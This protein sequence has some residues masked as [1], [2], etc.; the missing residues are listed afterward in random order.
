M[1][2]I[3]TKLIAAAAVCILAAVPAVNA[4]LSVTAS[5][6][7]GVAVSGASQFN[8]D[9]L[10]LS[11]AG[12]TVNSL[13]VIGSTVVVSF[14]SDGQ[15]VNLPNQS[16]YAAP[17]LSVNNGIGFGSHTPDLDQAN[18]QDSTH[19]LTS[20]LYN[21][22]ANGTPKGSVTLTFDSP[23]KYLGLL[24]GSV[25]SYN[26]LTFF[27]GSTESGFLE[28]GSLKGDELHLS[29]TFP[30]GNQSSEGTV[31][32]NIFSS[33][34]FTKVVATSEGSYAFE[35]DNV[36]ASAVPEPTTMIAGALLLLPFGVST[37]RML[38]KNRVA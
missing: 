27:S 25:D 6:G 20:G 9:T 21:T 16:T 2:K 29:S 33:E 11:S 19:Y 34:M 23:Q 32:A 22:E 8:F 7:G 12:G 36:A 30:Y 3:N 13:N 28:L 4:T 17:S 18:G 1:Q 5:V 31:Y 37:F 24:W 35:L 14:T 26:K 15:V 38:R 10:A